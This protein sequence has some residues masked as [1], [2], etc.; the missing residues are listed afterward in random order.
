M[1]RKRAIAQ[2]E[3]VCTGD[4]GR[5]EVGGTL[6]AL[7]SEAADARQGFY[8]QS[9]GE[10]GNPFDDRMAAGDE[11]EEELID[12]FALADDHFRK[13]TAN[14]RCECGKVLHG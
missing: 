6:H 8:C 7:K 10:T 13:F 4:I 5:H 11:N 1:Q 9:L 3:D 2:V 12:D 14:L